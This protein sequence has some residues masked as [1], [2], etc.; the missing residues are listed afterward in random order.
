[1]PIDTTTA[2]SPGWWLARLLGRLAEREPHL[3]RMFRYYDGDC[4]LP[5]GAQGA[6]EAYRR[7]QRKARVNFAELVVDAVRERME[8]VGF[9]TGASSDQ[10]A[11]DLAWRIWQANS[12]D[13][14]AG[15]VH[16]DSLVCGW[17]YAMVGGIDPGIDAPLI[18]AEDPRQVIT[19]CDPMQRRKVVAAAKTYRDDAAGADLAYLYLPGRVFRAARIGD[20]QAFGFDPT[21]SGWAWERAEGE[22]LPNLDGIVPVVPFPNRPKT[23]G[24]AAGEFEGVLDT[25][26]RINHM[27]LQRLVIATIQAFRQ[28]AIKGNLPTHDNLGNEIDYNGMFPSGPDA[29]WLLPEGAE[30]WESSQTDLAGILQSV[31]H[32]VQDLAATTRTPLFYLT[33]DANNGSAEGASLARE[34]LIFKTGDRIRQASEAWEQVMSIAFRVLGDEQR[35]SR[36]D[37]ELLWRPPER[38][39]LAER[40]DA[41]AKAQAAGVPWRTVMADVLQFSPQQIARMETERASDSFLTVPAASTA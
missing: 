29:L 34:G 24:P 5:E 31:R 4:D 2:L 8:P 20:E 35:S 6:R 32:D 7:F 30:L 38:F 16:T 33:P 28:R 10:G 37:M 14:D 19:E 11:D 27:L 22:P 39:S 41:A 1:L 12:L 3:D 13:A 26:D 17:G 40:Y 21:L 18:T 25:L 9:R 23:S 15:L 36:A